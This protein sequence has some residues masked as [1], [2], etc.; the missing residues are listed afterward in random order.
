MTA[1]ILGTLLAL[2]ALAYVLAPLFADAAPA[3]NVSSVGGSSVQTP[4]T[5][6]AEPKTCTTCGPR[7]ESDALYCSS[8]GRRL[9]D[10]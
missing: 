10:A 4:G 1:L 6:A 2:V 9:G 8:C 5:S 7:P 3:W